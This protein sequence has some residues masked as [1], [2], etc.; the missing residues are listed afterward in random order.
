[1]NIMLVGFGFGELLHYCTSSPFLR[2][3]SGQAWL[4]QNCWLNTS[5]HALTPKRQP[6]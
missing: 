3:R 1:M 2:K 5:Q 6:A 4:R